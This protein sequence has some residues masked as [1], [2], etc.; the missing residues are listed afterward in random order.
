M[1]TAD[2]QIGRVAARQYGVVARA[3]AHRCGLSD[4]QIRHRVAAGRWVRVHPGAFRIAGAPP[5]PE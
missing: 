4:K 3:Q 2:Q 5:T 1:P